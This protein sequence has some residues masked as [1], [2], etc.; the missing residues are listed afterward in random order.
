R[1]VKKEPES[2]SA[3]KEKISKIIGKS[4][5]GSKSNQKSADESAQA[6]NLMQIAKDWEEP[7]HLE[8]KTRVTEDQ[9]NEETSHLPDWFQK[10]TKPPTPD[11]DWNMTLPDAHGPVQP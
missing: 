3:P 5:E 4:T 10:S 2:T 7:A 9:P 11:C 8:F 1:R 6:E